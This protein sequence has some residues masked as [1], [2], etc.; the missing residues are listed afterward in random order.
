MAARFKKPWGAPTFHPELLAEPQNTRK[1]CRVFCGSVTDLGHPGV[2]PEWRAAISQAMRDAPQHTYMI[3]TKRPGPWL[4]QLPVATWCGV[5]AE[6]QEHY[7]ARWPMLCLYAGVATLLFVSV[8]PM[9]G[10]V[11]LAGFIYQPDWVIAGPETGRGARP[12]NDAWIDALAA[13]S[14]MF[15]DKRHGDWAPGR[16]RRREYPREAKP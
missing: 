3:L 12:C 5:S 8:E 15:F 10:P 16:P 2:Q 4:R 14:P 13:E 9:L 7:D 6:D 1:P 11:R